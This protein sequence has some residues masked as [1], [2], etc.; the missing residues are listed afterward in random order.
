MFTLQVTN[1]FAVPINWVTGSTVIQP[2]N[3]FETP[4]IGGF[5][6]FDITGIGP[7]LALDLGEGKIE[8]YDKAPGMNA[9]WGILFR[10][11]GVEVY[12][13]YESG[14]SFKITVDKYGDVAISAINGAMI[15][16]KLPGFTIE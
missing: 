11:Q 16:V 2:N 12:A 6:L 15:P 3:S 13:R 5:Q 9:T 7:L 10:F 4:G 8:G 1:N 14:G